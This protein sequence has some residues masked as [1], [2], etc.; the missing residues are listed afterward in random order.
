M[1]DCANPTSA[2]QPHTFFGGCM[3]FEMYVC[4]CCFVWNKP[5]KVQSSLECLIFLLAWWNYLHWGGALSRAQLESWRIVVGISSF[6]VGL[7]KSVFEGLYFSVRVLRSNRNGNG[8]ADAHPISG[9][10]QQ[11]DIHHLSDGAVSQ[12]HNKSRNTGGAIRRCALKIE[13]KLNKQ[14][15]V[16]STSS[17][18]FRICVFV[19]KMNCVVSRSWRH[20]MSYAKASRMKSIVP[21]PICMY[22]LYSTVRWCKSTNREGKRERERENGGSITTGNTYDDFQ[23]S[24]IWIWEKL[25][26]LIKIRTG[27]HVLGGSITTHLGEYKSITPWES[28][29]ITRQ[30]IECLK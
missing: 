23:E 21:Y 7:E 30:L 5:P 8:T 11:I 16:Q 6:E 10:N 19:C 25:F 14:K 1:N 29:T 4:C 17:A 12:P 9:A 15:T 20:Q 28:K 13:C 18:W 3:I 27:I 22:I 24:A 2:L 26:S